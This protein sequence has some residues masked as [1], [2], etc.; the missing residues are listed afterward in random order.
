M[1]SFVIPNTASRE[2]QISDFIHGQNGSLQ[3]VHYESGFPHVFPS[4][5]M[6]K[7]DVRGPMS[8]S[9]MDY[10]FDWR[11][12]RMNQQAAEQMEEQDDEHDNPEENS[13]EW[14]LDQEHGDISILEERGGER[15][16]RF[17]RANPLNQDRPTTLDIRALGQMT[18]RAI[19]LAIFRTWPDLVRRDRHWRIATVHRTVYTSTLVP[20]GTEVFLVHVDDEIDDDHALILHEFQFWRLGLKTY[21][22][23][24]VPRIIRR[25]KDITEFLYSTEDGHRCN[26]L[27]CTLRIN[28]V[29]YILP[30][31]VQITA[32]SLLVGM[33]F[34]RMDAVTQI[35][36]D[37]LADD[38]LEQLPHGYQQL[39]GVT[40]AI[41]TRLAPDRFHCDA[42][43]MQRSLA[44]TYHYLHQLQ[45]GDRIT[46]M[47][48]LIISATAFQNVQTP[49]AVSMMH[50]DL[51]DSHRDG[52]PQL[53][54]SLLVQSLTED[55]W[56]KQFLVPHHT[57]SLLDVDQTDH[58]LFLRPMYLEQP[59]R[60]ILVQVDSLTEFEGRRI[61]N[62]LEMMFIFS[63]TPAD[64]DGI[65][66]A[67]D[68]APECERH[69]CLV[70][71]NGRHMTEQNEQHFVPDGSACK[72]YVYLPPEE[73]LAR[74]PEEMDIDETHHER[75]H[76]SNTE[77]P[78]EES[79]RNDTGTFSYVP[80]MIGNTSLMVLLAM[81]QLR[82]DVAPVREKAT[83]PGSRKMSLTFRLLLLMATLVPIANA[84][85]LAGSLD[86]RRIGEAQNPG[87]EYWI[88]TV[89][90]TGIRGKEDTISKLPTGLWGIIE[91][92][93][94]GVNS[95]S[96][97]ATL[98]K[99]GHDRGRS[100]NLVQ[101]AKL[102]LRARS[103]T[104]GTW[105]G[106]L[107]MTDWQIRPIW[108][109][110]PN[111]EYQQGRIQLTQSWC[112][113][114]TITGACMY[115]WAKGPT[116]PNALKDTNALFDTIVQE[117]AMSRNGPRYIMG[118]MNHALQDLR[119]YAILQDLGWRD[120]Q[121]VANE[122]WDRTTC[123][124]VNRP[125]SLTMYC[126]HQN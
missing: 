4:G 114:F 35:V 90:P 112:G 103:Q 121:D 102:P 56:S 117:I 20:Q 106:V 77:R 60:I 31:M 80:G 48:I 126:C 64:R 34:D 109:P 101:G 49:Q 104:A 59:K 99:C 9:I 40:M 91:T 58:I 92:H 54:A 39:T 18:V 25:N 12:A 37:Y 74:L 61:I 41:G 24:L 15:I 11:Q 85:Q 105:A 93:L 75:I 100:L 95:R 28:G 76:E 115:G 42:Y 38:Y 70:I 125:R 98:K 63:H 81:A 16:W 30:Q 111:H 82:T 14:A 88:G 122:R 45:H 71:L 32:G 13:Q 94:S 46:G 123:S 83:R 73:A 21:T 43:C 33:S 50:Y 36:G 86:A 47:K 53:I 17:Y 26:V 113:P 110:W 29:D 3:K 6:E 27:P 97:L 116:W 108:T 69:E 44:S 65:L 52:F 72:I 120:S 19:R 68:L 10:Y 2:A 84:I 8:M 62:M 96:V 22:K 78:T 5:E 107:T 7:M 1:A 119:G 118:D 67:A 23:I 66:R 124:R 87:P 55:L 57:V 79:N 51:G 89:N